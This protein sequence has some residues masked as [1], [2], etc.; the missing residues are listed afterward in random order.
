[1]ITKSIKTLK[2]IAQDFSVL[3]VEDD[4][5]LRESTSIIFKDLFKEVII[6]GDGLAGL[7]LYKEHRDK[8]ES[9]FDIV[10]SDIQMPNMDGI[11]LSKEILKINKKQKI[12][13]VSA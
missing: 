7:S 11:A 13:I 12:I 4:E 10:I 1:M 5:R 2:D 3:Y 9:Y 6:A 8:T